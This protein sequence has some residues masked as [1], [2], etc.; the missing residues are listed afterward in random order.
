MLT[1][2]PPNIGYNHADFDPEHYPIAQWHYDAIA[3]IALQFKLPPDTQWVYQA[4]THGRVFWFEPPERIA[5][6]FTRLHQSQA[7]FLADLPGFRW[8]ENV[9]GHVGI[10]LEHSLDRVPQ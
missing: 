3:A 8:V 9:N 1:Q 7:K 2:T 5:R 4:T 10:G 6:M